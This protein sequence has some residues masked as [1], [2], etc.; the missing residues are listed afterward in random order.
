MK[1]I[2]SRALAV[3]T[4]LFQRQTFVWDGTC[5][6]GVHM[7][8]ARGSTEAPGLG[9]IGVVAFNASMLIPNSSIAAVDYPA[10]FENYFTSYATGASEF[11]RLVLEHVKAC[12]D[13]KIALLGYSQG[14]HA[15]MD[16]VCGNSDDDFFVNPDLKK[17]L[18]AQVVAVV[19]FGD[20]SY[21][22]TVGLGL[23]WNAGTSTGAG[24]FARRN[25]TTCEP[26]AAKIRSW[27][28]TGDV[29][30]DLGDLRL[31]HGSYFANYT[32]DAAEFIAERFNSSEPV[33]DPST[34]TAP[35]STTTTETATETTTD[36]A[37]ET[38][39]ET[40]AETTTTNPPGSGAGSFSPSWMMI[41]PIAAS[42]MVWTEL[43]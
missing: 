37:T 22:A 2:L 30:C 1:E 39:T 24:L 7:I 4:A 23:G 5:A 18:G 40:T 17:A 14:A 19:G 38:T 42:M 6:T 32:L 11:E 43:L 33:I 13:T 9:R 26:Y 21:N 16:A 36:T 8:V 12:P 20:P 10:T 35:P 29:Y 34:T 15:L 41:A 25:I 28:D 27:C 31:I 3:V